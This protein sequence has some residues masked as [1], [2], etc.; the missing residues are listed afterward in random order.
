MDIRD[1]LEAILGR[2]G[3]D[4]TAWKGDDLIVRTPVTGEVIASLRASTPVETAAVVA[5]A[6]EAFLAWRLVPAPR[7]GELVRRLGALLREHKDDLGM[8]VSIE[9]G[10]IISEGQGEGQKRIDTSD[11]S[12]GH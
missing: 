4:L 10:K 3:V 5:R 1:N 9:A 8:L 2:L 6:R 7:R 12:V 11:L